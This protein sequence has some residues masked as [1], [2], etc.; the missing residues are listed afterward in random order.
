MGLFTQGMNATCFICERIAGS[1]L[2]FDAFD[3]VGFQ[4]IDLIHSKAKSSSCFSCPCRMSRIVSNA[5][6]QWTTEAYSK[7]DANP[8]P[9][10]STYKAGLTWSD[11]LRRNRWLNLIH[12]IS[13]LSII[14][15]YWIGFSFGV[16]YFL[17]FLFYFQHHVLALVR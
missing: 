1:S 16:R 7:E 14:V 17:F 11:H 8:A 12:R 6:G 13:H 5:T 3:P 2:A 15:G 10:V 9:V 4:E